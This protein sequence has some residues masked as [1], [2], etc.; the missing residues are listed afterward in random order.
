MTGITAYGFAESFTVNAKVAAPLPTVPATI[1]APA[2]QTHV[3]TP[4]ITISGT[5]PAD[6]Y[7]KLYQG[8]VFSGLQVCGSSDSIYSFD[9]ELQAGANSLYTRIFNVT[10]DEGPQSATITVWYD[11]PAHATPA[12]STSSPAST[13]PLAIIAEDYQYHVYNAGQLITWTLHIEGG[14][15]PYTL[16]VDWGD[17]TSTNSSEA[18]QTQFEISH[19]YDPSTKGNTTY[20]IKLAARDTKGAKALLQLSA[21][22]KADSLPISGAGGT[23]NDSVTNNPIPTWLKVAW[24]SY[25]VVTLM[26]LSFWLGERQEVFTIFH[27][28]IKPRPRRHL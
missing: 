7:V 21:V 10:D 27:R 17:G 12:A 20:V 4:S 23:T 24:P 1:T 2:D 9:V 11:V 25:A 26:T 18:D 14:V 3:S 13:Q 19:S 15:A 8:D 22:V 16:T 5:C 28:A 6:T